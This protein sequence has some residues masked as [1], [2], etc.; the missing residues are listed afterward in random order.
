MNQPTP[1]FNRLKIQA[2]FW[3]LIVAASPVFAKEALHIGSRGP[4]GGVVFHVDSDGHGLEAKF[5]DEPALLTW[6]AAK[7]A[8]GAYGDGWRLPSRVELRLLYQQKALIGGFSNGDYWSAGEHD[9]ER[10]SG[11]RHRREAERERDLR[12]HADESGGTDDERDIGQHRR[13]DEVSEYAALADGNGDGRHVGSL[14]D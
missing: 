2:V 11:D 5:N 10:L 4:G 8:A 6:P 14:R 1:A 12:E 9:A 13:G 7:A 3:L